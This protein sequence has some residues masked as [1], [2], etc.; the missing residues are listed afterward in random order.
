L[1]EIRA[2]A[3][4]LHI[5]SPGGYVTDGMLIYNALRDHPARTVPTVDALAA[6]AASF[7][8]MAGDEVV[9]NR[10][11]ELMIH[12]PLMLCAGNAEDRRQCAEDLD[13]EDARIAGVYELLRWFEQH[14]DEE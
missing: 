5:N 14:R 6:S 7:V 4:D 12:S 8:A 11:S 9:M 13:R 2:S 1:G 10:H 3:I